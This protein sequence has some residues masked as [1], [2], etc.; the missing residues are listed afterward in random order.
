[1]DRVVG[2]GAEVEETV[3]GGGE[4]AGVEVA[5]RLETIVGGVGVPFGGAG[6]GLLGWAGVFG[7]RLVEGEV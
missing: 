2:G 3:R 6:P 1:V 4:V 5:H 7:P